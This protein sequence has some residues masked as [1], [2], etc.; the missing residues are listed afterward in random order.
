MGNGKI[1]FNS[2]AIRF[3]NN[4]KCKHF[5]PLGIEPSYQKLIILP[6]E[7]SVPQTKGFTIATNSRSWLKPKPNWIW[8]LLSKYIEIFKP[9]ILKVIDFTVRMYI[10]RDWLHTMW[11]RETYFDLAPIFYACPAINAPP[12]Q[13]NAFCIHFNPRTLPHFRLT[14]IWT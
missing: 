3:V 7:L 9:I 6:P 2:L 4:K 11:N 12:R 14:L 13:S 10:T 5:L 1:Y 8:I